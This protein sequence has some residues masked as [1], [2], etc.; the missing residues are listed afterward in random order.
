[1]KKV[2]RKDVLKVLEKVKEPEVGLDVVNMGLIYEVKVADN[3]EI[4]MTVPCPGCHISQAIVE[5]VAEAVKKAFKK[6]PKIELVF[7]PPWTIQMMS[8][9]AKKELKTRFHH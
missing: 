3:I 2:T 5:L 6:K 7:D 8:E 1:M 9:K 4:R